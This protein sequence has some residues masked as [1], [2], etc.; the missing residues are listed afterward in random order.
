MPQ[1]DPAVFPPQLVW[2]TISFVILYLVMA[3]VVL[4]RIGDVIEARQDRIA[5]DLDAAASLETEAET[6]LA[7]YEKSIS[8]ARSEARD[9]LVKAAEQRAGDAAARGAKLDA[10]IAKRVRTAEARIA[11]AKQDALDNLAGV[12]GEIA[13][14]ATEKLIGVAPGG[15]TVEAA[16]AQ[17]TQEL[18]TD[19]LATK[20][21]D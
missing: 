3:R 18:A 9:V 17:A 16:L 15:A 10:R 5:H 12:A 19:E 4:P 1:L 8:A 13:R 7:E 20:D 11:A 2:L 14:A 6:A 21:Q